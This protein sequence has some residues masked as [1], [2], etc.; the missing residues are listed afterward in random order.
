M[1]LTRHSSLWSLG[2][3]LL[4]AASSKGHRDEYISPSSMQ[5]DRQGIVCDQLCGSH[6][7]NSGL[8]VSST[9]ASALVCSPD[10][11]Q[12]LLSLCAASSEGLALSLWWSQISKLPQVIMD[13][14]GDNNFVLSKKKKIPLPEH[15]YLFYVI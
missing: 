1:F 5:H 4:L 10:G 8:L 13:E 3:A 14:W 15:N 9:T 6:T 7:L 12:S 2:P 11:V